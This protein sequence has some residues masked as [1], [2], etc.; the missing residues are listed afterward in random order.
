[1]LMSPRKVQSIMLATGV[2][3]STDAIR[4][5]LEHHIDIALLDKLG[6]PYGR[7]WHTRLGS[8]NRLRAPTARGR[9]DRGRRHA[10]SA[11]GS[12]PRSATRPGCSATSHDPARPR[13]RTGSRRRAARQDGR[14]RRRGQG[15]RHRRDPR[16]DHGARRR[17]RPRV[18]RRAEPGPARAVPLPGPQPLPREG[19]VQCP[20]QLRLRR[21]L[22][23]GR[24]GLPAQRAGP[25]HRPD[26][27][28]QLQ[29]AVTGLRPDRAAPRARRA[30]GRQP[31][32]VAEG[33]A[34]ALRPG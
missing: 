2:H 24:T 28:R 9:R 26:A 22:L 29:Q 20:A 4:L 16:L 12:R 8:T 3:L 10:G 34:G 32:R 21:A 15:R 31:V 25:L 17:R 19:R 27:H 14:R 33:E 18:L 1:M 7:F 11:S 23:A 13:R 5:A 30:C 6:E